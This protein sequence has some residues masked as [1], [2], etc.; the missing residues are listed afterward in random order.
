M[1]GIRPVHTHEKGMLT[2]FDEHNALELGVLAAKY[3]HRS[4][5]TRFCF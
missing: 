5:Q 3:M 1:A 2:L 4:H